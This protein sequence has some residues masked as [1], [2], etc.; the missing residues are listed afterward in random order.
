MTLAG[1][2]RDL[3]LADLIIVKSQEAG[4]TRFRLSG[5]AG[6]GILLIDG[7][8]VVHAAYGE[9]PAEDAAFLLVTE[10]NVDF[11]VEHGV[12]LK[13]QTLDMGVQEL[14]LE[15]MRRLDEGILRRPRPVSIEVGASA[16]RRE[17]PR[18]RSHA[19]KQTPETEA[20][21]RATGRVLFAETEPRP[22][23]MSKGFVGRFGLAAAGI[24]A[25]GVVASLAWRSGLIVPLGPRDPVDLLDLAG[26]NDVLPLLV[27][28]PPAVAPESAMAVLPT[29]LCDVVIDARGR[30]V[31]ASVASPR[32]GLEAFER[33]AVRA[34]GAY[35]FSSASREGIPVRVRM[36]WPVDFVPAPEN[37][38]PVPVDASF[39]TTVRDKRPE[40][41]EGN[42]PSSP[43]PERRLRPRIECRLLIDEEGSVVEAEVVRPREDLELYERVALDAVR[44]Y[45]FTPGEREGVRVPVYMLY[46]VEFQ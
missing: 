31:G 17:A 21:R 34:V 30:V 37:E 36:R 46:T 26:P 35:R 2:T 28:G 5:P 8:R 1:N 9:L 7:G 11:Q 44:D 4:T 39:F 32:R 14:L 22:P 13:G 23:A 18:P 41:L 33:A 42:P 29:I 24:V 16:Y 43:I 27:S 38:E 19:A 45:R 40:K 10:E 6:D 20:L 3:S 12:E 15:S 25:F